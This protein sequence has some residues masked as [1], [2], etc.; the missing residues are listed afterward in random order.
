MTNQVS[1][2]PAPHL[3]P[4]PPPGHPPLAPAAEQDQQCSGAWGALDAATA[5]RAAAVQLP[6][7]AHVKLCSTVWGMTTTLQRGPA[8][9]PTT[10]TVAMS[11]PT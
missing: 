1:W 9:P 5:K 8:H 4:P 3:P 10:H 6:G 7:H 11:M 2:S